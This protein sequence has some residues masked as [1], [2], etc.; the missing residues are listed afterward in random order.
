MGSCRL[1]PPPTRARASPKPLQKTRTR[2]RRHRRHALHSENCEPPFPVNLFYSFLLLRPP[3][4]TCPDRGKFSPRGFYTTRSG[5]QCRS[6]PHPH[7]F[8]SPFS[9]NF[10]KKLRP[11]HSTDALYKN[12][13]F[14]T[15]EKR[16]MPLAVTC[17]G[18]CK[19]PTRAH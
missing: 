10:L 12:K 9:L 19:I 11:L 17:G 4:F 8:F 14:F 18:V 5:A 6:A 1:P 3:A 16:Y 7:S 13:N 15:I 2:T